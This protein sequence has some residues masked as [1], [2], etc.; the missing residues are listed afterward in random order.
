MKKLFV[1]VILASFTCCTN[2]KQQ[3]NNQEAITPTESDSSLILPS[4][5]LGLTLYYQEDLA[6]VVAKVKKAF[7][8]KDS[9]VDGDGQ[10]TIIANNDIIKTE[11]HI[12]K[13][14]N[15]NWLDYLTISYSSNKSNSFDL[16]QQL[17]DS[18]NSLYKESS[19]YKWDEERLQWTDGKSYVYIQSPK[20]DEKSGEIF[21]IVSIMPKSNE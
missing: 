12:I 7:H 8:L 13:S 5:N 20:R 14:S 2:T 18:V 15:P 16:L 1:L 9:P 4:P 11:Y 17:T 21:A 10:L 6:N 3:S 19:L